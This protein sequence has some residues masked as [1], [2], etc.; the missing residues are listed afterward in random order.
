MPWAVFSPEPRRVSP[1]GFGLR[2]GCSSLPALFSSAVG[3]WPSPAALVVCRS[4]SL[5]PEE[6]VCTLTATFPKS[7]LN[8]RRVCPGPAPWV[9]TETWG[10][11]RTLGLHPVGHPRTGSC[12][13]AQG[14]PAPGAWSCPPPALGT[15]HPVTPPAPSPAGSVWPAHS[16]TSPGQP[17]RNACPADTEACMF[18]QPPHHVHQ[19]HRGRLQ[20]TPMASLP[21]PR[22]RPPAPS[23]RTRTGRI[24]PSPGSDS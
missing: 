18:P 23:R 19:E 10:L 8:L 20:L 16:H 11:G 6:L 3:P 24:L 2:W 21:T 12:A 1:G 9:T 4:P 17:V 7:P 14:S 13:G 15:A 22:A 5:G